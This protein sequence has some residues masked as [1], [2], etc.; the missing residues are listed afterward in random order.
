MFGGITVGLLSILAK[1]WFVHM[2]LGASQQA[3][4]RRRSDD[5]LVTPEVKSER[6]VC[7]RYEKMSTQL[8]WLLHDGGRHSGPNTRP[9]W[10]RLLRSVTG[11]RWR[12][13]LWSELS[14]DTTGR[15]SH[16]LA[17]N[18]LQLVLEPFQADVLKGSELNWEVKSCNLNPV[19]TFSRA[20]GFI[21]ALEDQWEEDHMHQDDLNLGL[22]PTHSVVCKQEWEKHREQVVRCF[23]HSLIQQSFF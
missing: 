12:R 22:T 2:R 18:S 8:S 10:S 11:R 9:C 21:K 20:E 19:V 7:K 23:S 13:R 14:C 16:R 15:L 3:G 4:L 6:C 5:T 1:W 17:P